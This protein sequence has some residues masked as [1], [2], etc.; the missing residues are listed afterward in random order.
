MVTAEHL[1]SFNAVLRR[2]RDHCNGKPAVHHYSQHPHRCTGRCRKHVCKPLGKA[3][4]RKINFIISGAYQTAIRWEWLTHNPVPKVKLP[5]APAPDPRPPSPEEAARIINHAWTTGDY[6]G[7]LVW[8]AMTIGARR[9]ELC[10]LRW[11]DIRV[12]H[13]ISEEHNRI[14]AACDWWFEIRSSVGQSENRIWIKD[15]KTSQTRLVALDVETIAVLID[16]RQQCDAIAATAGM[17]VVDVDRVE[18][19]RRLE[20]PRCPLGVRDVP[21]AVGPG[22]RGVGA[23]LVEWLAHP[24]RA[25]RSR[26]CG[27]PR[28]TSRGEPPPPR[29]SNRSG[30]AS[31]RCAARCPRRT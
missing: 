1:E 23:V 13:T 20:L 4:N 2:C 16:H 6:L 10:G 22:D 8:I 26:R 28:R 27:P 21:R 14:T 11:S 5:S 19:E 15:T 30:T 17:T 25:T 7:P 3:T 31:R 24:H 12:R 29:P 18:R 9:G